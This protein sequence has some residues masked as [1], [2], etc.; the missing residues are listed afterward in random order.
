MLKRIAAAGR[1]KGGEFAPQASPARQFAQERAFRRGPYKMKP[2]D[3]PLAAASSAS[4]RPLAPY[5]TPNA[6]P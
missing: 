1:V 6:T 4:R 3:V 5:G 2:E